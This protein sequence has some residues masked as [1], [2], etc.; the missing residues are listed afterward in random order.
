MSDSFHAVTFDPG[1]RGRAYGTFMFLYI[2]TDIDYQI[3]IFMIDSNGLDI[4]TIKIEGCQ[5]ISHFQRRRS[6][7]VTSHRNHHFCQSYPNDIQFS[8]KFLAFFNLQL[9]YIQKQREII[10]KLSG[11]RT[12]NDI[13]RSVFNLA[14]MLTNIII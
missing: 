12:K 8:Y 9:Q 10:K 4:G 14:G 3:T 2:K 7:S 1:S 5:K 11:K 6:C 13:Y